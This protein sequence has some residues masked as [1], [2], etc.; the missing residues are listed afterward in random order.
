MRWERL[1]DDLETMLA[2]EERRELDAEVADRTRRERAQVDLLERLAAARHTGVLQLQVTGLGALG[3]AVL[4]V[5]ADWLLLGM[6]P[7]RGALVPFAA[8]TSVVGLAGRTAPA[9]AVARGFTLG[10]A[11]RAV[12]RDRAAVTVVDVL[13]RRTTGTIDAVGADWLDLAEHS[14]DL[15]RRPENVRRHVTVPLPA[16][17]AVLRE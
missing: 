1:F 16:V 7:E 10:A 3:G 2:E 13:G 17:A 5:G 12:S 6:T 15:P 14:A 8:V 11:L 9:G 4:D